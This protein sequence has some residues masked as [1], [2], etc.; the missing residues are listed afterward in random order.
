MLKTAIPLGLLSIATYL[1][2]NGHT[3]KIYDRSVD[4]SGIKKTLNS[5][6]P[7]IVGISAIGFRSFPDAIKLSK[8]IKNSGLNV[9]W[10]GH[11]P[12]LIPEI[13]LNSGAV[14]YV[15]MGEGEITWLALLNAITGETQLSEIDGLAFVENGA[16]VV[17]K[18]RD[19]T[20]LSQLPIIDFSFVDPK[21][22]FSSNVS[23]KKMLH[24]YSSKGCPYSCTYCYNPHYSECTW[25]ARPTAYF[26]SEIKYLIDNYYMDGVYFAD[27]LLGPSIDYVNGFCNDIIASG[28]KFYWGCD[29]RADTCTR[30][31]LDMM[32]NAGCRWIFFG[33]ESGCLE[34]QKIIKKG[35]NLIKAKETIDYCRKK[36]I[37]TT[38]SFIIGFPD[39]TEEELMRTVWYIQELNSFT[40]NISFFGPVPKSEM[41]NYL[42]ENRKIDIPKTYKD[43]LKVKCGDQIGQNYSNV[44]KRE[45]KVVSAHYLWADFIGKYP[46]DEKESRVFAKKAFKQILDAFKQGNPNY[47]I[48]YIIISAKQILSIFYYANMFPRIL[49]K[50]KL[51]SSKT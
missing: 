23:C 39:E 26:L 18:K 29:L 1:T 30:E 34:R 31:E 8:I 7:D 45:L 10:G 16:F 25:R 46:E 19:F 12:S 20:D 9:V 36:G 14:D 50:Y 43:W 17:N 13:V 40:T 3:V 6:M 28:M 24:I 11:I 35:I 38:A 32:Y 47:L 48:F 33:I 42:V 44:P 4:A 15:V 49:A 37:V 41:Y 2:N 5:F 51:K 22:Y 27:D 21:K